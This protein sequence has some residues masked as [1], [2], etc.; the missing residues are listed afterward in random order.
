MSPWTLPNPPEADVLAPTRVFELGGS[1]CR[2]GMDRAALCLHGA[3]GAI[4]LPDGQ[5]MVWGETADAVVAGLNRVNVTSGRQER[6]L[7]TPGRLTVYAAPDDRVAWIFVHRPA[8]WSP[9]ILCADLATRSLT[10]AVDAFSADFARARVALEGDRRDIDAEVLPDGTLV[11]ETSSYEEIP[12]LF[13]RTRE[14]WGLRPNSAIPKDPSA[15]RDVYSRVLL[16][17][18]DDARKDKPG[19][20]FEVSYESR[21]QEPRMRKRHKWSVRDDQA[22]NTRL[23]PV[24]TAPEAHGIMDP[25]LIP[26]AKFRIQPFELR[27]H[28]QTLRPCQEGWNVVARERDMILTTNISNEN[29]GRICGVYVEQVTDGRWLRTLNHGQCM[30]GVKELSG[31]LLLFGG[32]GDYLAPTSASLW[33]VRDGR[34][35]ARLA[36]SEKERVGFQTKFVLL[37]F[38]PDRRQIYGVTGYPIPT[39]VQWPVT[40]SVRAALEAKV[41]PDP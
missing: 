17:P 2:P 15:T 6:V 20:R 14:A 34:L 32:S 27:R 40:A 23:G 41:S 3:D 31:A 35:L 25:L 26:D 19:L 10:R 24:F 29:C 13:S 16:S 36:L 33:D 4:W 38:S 22:R 21:I 12:E 30:P 11:L 37:S 8:E 39:V 7:T 5:M 9:E 1:N 18:L 28:P